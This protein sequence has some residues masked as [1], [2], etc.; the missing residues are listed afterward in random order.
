MLQLSI[1]KGDFR[2]DVS[3]AG[4]KPSD[5]NAFN[6]GTKM[7]KTIKQL[8]HSRKRKLAALKA[9][10]LQSD[11]RFTWNLYK[12]TSRIKSGSKMQ[13]QSGLEHMCESGSRS[14]TQYR[15]IDRALKKTNF[16]FTQLQ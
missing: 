13:K 3:A 5:L 2:L 15:K 7:P 9:F 10:L 16:S 8:A 14:I 4:E 6:F 12:G 11:V 1:K